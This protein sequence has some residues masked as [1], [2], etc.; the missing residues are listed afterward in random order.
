MLEATE[1]ENNFNPRPL[2]RGRPIRFLCAQSAGY[3]SIHAPYAG[4]DWRSCQ[5]QRRHGFYFNPRPLCRGRRAMLSVGLYLILF[6][7]TPPMQGATGAISKCGGLSHNFNPRPLC[8]GRPVL[9]IKRKAQQS[10]FNPRPLCRGRLHH[11][12]QNQ[13]SHVISI[14]A[15]YAGGD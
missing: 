14:H 3:I 11:Q 1:H 15:P 12:F 2:C 8:R 10:N 7:S 9:G 4:G 13:K 6:Q 5:W